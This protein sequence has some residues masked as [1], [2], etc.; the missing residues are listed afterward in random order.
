MR[1]ERNKERKV[2]FPVLVRVTF[3]MNSFIFFLMIHE[4][5]RYTQY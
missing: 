4:E 2:L 5:I 1:K 3:L